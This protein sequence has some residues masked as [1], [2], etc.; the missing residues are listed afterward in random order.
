MADLMLWADIAITGDGL[1]KYETAVTGTP[2]IMLST[3]G[4]A[5]ALNLEF[6]RAR[7]TQH[8]GDGGV[9]SVETIAE[10]TR[11]LMSD[12]ARRRKM[13]ENGRAMVDGAGIERIFARLPVEVFADA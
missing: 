12:V 9:V 5:K 6:E 3:A 10:A 4:S 13:S 2:S 1:T 8:L 11:Q 7:T